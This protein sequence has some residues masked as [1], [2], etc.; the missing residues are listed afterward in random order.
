MKN[1]SK[2]PRLVFD[3]VRPP[4]HRLDEVEQGLA[5]KESLL[6][7]VQL[8]ERGWPV[9][10][11]DD[12]WHG[13]LGGIR[14]NLIRL[15]EIPSFRMIKQWLNGDIIIIVTRISLSLTL[16]AKLLNKKVIFLDAMC[17]DVPSRLWRRIATK[18]ALNLADACICF[19]TTQA[20]HWARELG[21][22]ETKF[23]PL[24]YFIDDKFLY[25]S[26]RLPS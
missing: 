17:E 9:S 24:N 23:T 22:P 4:G 26:V 14:S 19:S 8:K 5:P 15:I 20:A 11:S 21:L 3:F 7:Y 10:T 13:L 6:G 16:I 2:K 12:R 18:Q 1:S 25:T